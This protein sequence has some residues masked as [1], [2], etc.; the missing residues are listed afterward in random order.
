MRK[1]EWTN[2]PLAR[3]DEFALVGQ[4]RRKENS[5]RHLCDFTGL[6]TDRP[7]LHPNGASTAGVVTQARNDRKQQKANAHKGKGVAV[8]LEIARPLDPP[9]R[10]DEPHDSDCR[11]CCLCRRQLFVEPGD[12]DVAETIQQ[13]DRW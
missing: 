11:P 4:V 10:D 5:E 1:S 7:Q 6:K 8:A 3:C 12:H 13:C 2:L 9:E